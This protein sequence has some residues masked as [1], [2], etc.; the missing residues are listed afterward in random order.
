MEHPLLIVASLHRGRGGLQKSFFFN[1]C[2]SSASL[3]KAL[4]NWIIRKS[5]NFELR[6]EQE[7]RRKPRVVSVMETT[8]SRQIS[9]GA[10]PHGSILGKRPSEWHRLSSI[11]KLLPTA[12]LSM[13]LQHDMVF[14]AFQIGNFC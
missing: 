1:L 6:K 2:D 11:H 7:V 13:S 9:E 12:R 8:V 4:G 3:S 10:L 14:H 5:A